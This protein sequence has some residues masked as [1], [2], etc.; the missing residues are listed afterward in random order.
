MSKKV[1]DAIR[2]TGNASSPIRQIEVIQGF[3]R[4]QVRQVLST[5]IMKLKGPE[6]FRFGANHVPMEQYGFKVGAKFVERFADAAALVLRKHQVVL[7]SP[8]ASDVQEYVRKAYQIIGG[9]EVLREV[10]PPEAFVPAA[11]SIAA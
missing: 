3:G 9:E 8:G 1:V 7:A 10:D 11:E 2:R 4:T 5:P 6:K